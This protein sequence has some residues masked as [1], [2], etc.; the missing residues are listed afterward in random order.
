MIAVFGFLNLI[1]CSS[2]LIFILY[3]R[4]IKKWKVLQSQS[5]CRKAKATTAG[6]RADVSTDI[7]L[8][9]NLL[10]SDCIQALGFIVGGYWYK[11]AGIGLKYSVLNCSIQG[12]F[13]ELGDAATACFVILIALHTLKIFVTPMNPKINVIAF[14]CVL[15]IV[16][17]G[18]LSMTFVP[19]YLHHDYYDNVGIWCW[20]TPK[21]TW[22]RLSLHYIYLFAAMIVSIFVYGGLGIYIWINRKQLGNSE[23][24]KVAKRMVL[25]PLSY[26]VGCLPIGSLRVASM[27][28]A[29][30]TLRHIIAGCVLFSMLGSINCAIYI[31]TRYGVVQRELEARRP[32]ILQDSRGL[33]DDTVKIRSISPTQFESAKFSPHSKSVVC[34]LDV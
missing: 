13:I 28:G 29:D 16:W 3:H 14:R 31:F 12:F 24:T 25:Y 6:T 8:L 30:I 20:I 7:T 19:R 34:K 11:R 5:E 15:A 27:A 10:I 23:V 1:A 21:Y 4:Q 32:T 18:A 2:V 33:S 26:T 9:I 17:L 22:A